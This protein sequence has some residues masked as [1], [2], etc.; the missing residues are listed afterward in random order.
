MAHHSALEHQDGDGIIVGAL[1]MAKLQ[2][3]L[4]IWEKGPLSERAVQSVEKV[5][6]IAEPVAYENNMMAMHK[7]MSK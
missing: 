4:Q 7:I 2:E 1:T 6:K 3:T 5:W